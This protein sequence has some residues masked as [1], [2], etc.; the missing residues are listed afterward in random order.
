MSGLALSPRI[1]ATIDKPELTEVAD[2]IRVLARDIRKNVGRILGALQTGDISRQRAEH[3]QS[4]LALLHELDGS[5]IQLGLRAGG[6]IL[7]AAQLEAALQDYSKEVSKLIPGIEGLASDALALVS[8]SDAVTDLG[9]SGHDVGDL[10]LRMDAAAQLFAEIQ[11][12]DGAARYLA[13]RLANEKGA[14]APEAASDP[15]PIDQRASEFQDRIVYMEAAADD[16]VVILERLKD[17]AEALIGDHPANVQISD[18]S[19]EPKKGLAVAARIKAIRDKAET[20]MAAHAGKNTDIIRLLTDAGN[21]ASAYDSD[22]KLEASGDVSLRFAGLDV[23]PDGD[24]FKREFV[25]LL[26]KMDCLYTMSAERE[27]HRAFTKACGLETAE[28]PDAIEDGL[29]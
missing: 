7:L 28:E 3:V 14:I 23:G 12:A 19:P 10:K 29:F 25:V 5:P 1:A 13:G 9:D 6:E 26:A 15:Y 21:P 22:D 4:G 18:V 17:V 16:C 2:Q 27:V 8:L 24:A 11:A 20:D